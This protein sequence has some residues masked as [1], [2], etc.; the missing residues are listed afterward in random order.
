MIYRRLYT[1]VFY[2]ITKKAISI[3]RFG[4]YVINQQYIALG[5]TAL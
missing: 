4:R 2:P 1:K 5:F 3:R